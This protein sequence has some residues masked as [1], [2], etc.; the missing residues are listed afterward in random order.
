MEDEIGSAAELFEVAE[1]RDVVMH[2]LVAVRET[3]PD[4]EAL[5]L[6][7]EVLHAPGS[8]DESVAM[9]L[10]TC[11]GGLE[12]RVRVAV[13]TRNEYAVFCVDAEAVFALPAPIASSGQDIVEEF[14]EQIGGPA[15]FPYIRTAVAA[16]AAQLSVPAAPLPLLHAVDMELATDELTP[17]HDDDEHL[18]AHPEDGDEDRY[19]HGTYAEQSVITLGQDNQLVKTH[20]EADFMIDTQT[21][22][23]V[24]IGG[25][26]DIDVSKVEVIA[27]MLQIDPAAFWPHLRKEGDPAQETGENLILTKLME[28]YTDGIKEVLDAADRGEDELSDGLNI[29]EWPLKVINETDTHRAVVLCTGSPHIEVT[30]DG[31]T[32]ARLEG[33]FGS[34][35]VTFCDDAENTYARFLD[36]Y[37][38]KD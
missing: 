17:H 14:I 33:Y 24:Q 5:G 36:L 3:E 1:L 6:P 25:E 8:P 19:V 28:I 23:L 35:Y 18:H 29:W 27:T 7:P 13:R 22:Q 16:L 2:Q 37:I 32:T 10:R 12:L 4:P 34:E 31:G 30:T 11:V 9:E 20:H 26:G 15:V 21:Q 38:E